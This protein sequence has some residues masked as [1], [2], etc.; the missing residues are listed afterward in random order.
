MYGGYGDDILQPSE[1]IE[2]ELS[3]LKTWDGGPG[4]DHL[5][6]NEAIIIADAAFSGGTGN[7]KLDMS[8]NTMA[9]NRRIFGGCG[10]D[11]IYGGAGSGYGLFF[12]DHSN[13]LFE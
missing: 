3:S 6:L 10:D 5:T 8:S 7:D 11:L 12:G 13:E 1:G 4:D 2:N 9:A